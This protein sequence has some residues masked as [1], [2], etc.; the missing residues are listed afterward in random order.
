MGIVDALGPAVNHLTIG[1][2]VI[3]RNSQGGNWAEYAIIQ[4]AKAYPVPDD[5]PDEQ[6]ASFLINP[7]TA[8]LML[9]HVLAV[10]PGQ[11]LLQSAAGS[12]LGRM[13][14]RLAKRDGIKTLN[15]VRRKEA[16][17]ELQALG[18]DAVL[19][20][21]EAPIDEQVRNIVGPDGVNYAVDAVAGQTGTEMFRSLSIDGRMLL[22][23]SLTDQPVRVGEDPRFTLSGRRRLEVY[24][25]GYWLPRLDD[26]GFFSNGRSAVAQLI[27]EIVALVREGVLTTTPGANYPL[28]LIRD[29]V[30][31]AESPG[32]DGTVVIAPGQS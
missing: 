15:I 10:P 31:E 30:T 18:A 1:Q 28:N 25:L 19:I 20:S 11:W 12:E 7:A 17:A 26:S 21:T 14:I 32:R 8:I 9:R 22:Y 3:C 16:L 5:I 27:D 6:V 2:R 24:W 13:I 4:A 23:G 29:A